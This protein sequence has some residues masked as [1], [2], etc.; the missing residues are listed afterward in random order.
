MFHN[1]LKT[2]QKTPNNSEQIHTLYKKFEI[3]NFQF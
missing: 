1:I 3:I 2:T